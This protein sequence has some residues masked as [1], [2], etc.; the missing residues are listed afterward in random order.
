[1]AR[2]ASAGRWTL[3]GVGDMSR[4]SPG[5]WRGPNEMGWIQSASGRVLCGLKSA[6]VFDARLIAAAPEMYRI[7]RDHRNGAMNR[8][9]FRRLA[10]ALL[11]RIDGSE[12]DPK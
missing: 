9:E 6:T 4:F 5:P 3:M 8:D 7:I 11:A 10:D 12:T 2:D 1:M